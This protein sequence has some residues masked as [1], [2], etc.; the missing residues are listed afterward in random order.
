MILKNF[1]EKS[2]YCN[3]TLHIND[4]LEIVKYDIESIHLKKN[5]STNNM[6]RITNANEIN[7]LNIER[8][9]IMKYLNL[10][11]FTKRNPQQKIFDYWKMK[12]KIPL[13]APE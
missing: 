12:L 1:L 11:E 9:E 3:I 6:V 8:T 10:I 2:G 13:L 4:E 7:K 5:D